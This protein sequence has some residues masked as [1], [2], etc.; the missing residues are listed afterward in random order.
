MMVGCK[1]DEKQE[2]NANKSYGDINM[3]TLV[4]NGLIFSI[5]TGKMKN[6]VPIQLSVYENGKYIV[7]T[8]YKTAKDGE[9]QTSML[10]YSKSIEGKYDYDVLKIIKASAN[11][12][13]ITIPDSLFEYE[14]YTGIGQRFIVESGVTNKYLEEFLEQINV[15]LN[16]CAEKDYY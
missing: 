4:N 6:C 15:D 12:E 10:Q 1:K 3:E 13:N 11:V 5:T 16:V 14:I 8:A 9:I 2:N 7:H